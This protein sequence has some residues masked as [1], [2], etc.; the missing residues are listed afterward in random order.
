MSYLTPAIGAKIVKLVIAGMLAF[1]LLLGYVFIQSYVGRHNLAKAEHTA[2]QE[3][4]DTQRAGCNRAKRDRAAAIVTYQSI[5]MAFQETDKQIPGPITELRLDAEI[6]IKT[7]IDDLK[8]RSEI[9]CVKEFP[10]Q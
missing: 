10:K 4:V 9:D 7:S 8:K 6:G 2:R 5:L 3:L 1:L